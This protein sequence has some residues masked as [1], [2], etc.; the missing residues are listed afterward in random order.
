[1]TDLWTEASRD[2]DDEQN[3][4]LQATASVAA[5]QF[6]PFLAAAKT[7]R[8]F[9]HRLGYVQDEFLS[10]LAE[11]PEH[12]RLATL[13]K[14]REDFKALASTRKTASVSTLSQLHDQL[15]DEGYRVST[16]GSLLEVRLAE[17]LVLVKRHSGND[18]A[19]WVDPGDGGASS[20]DV[21]WYTGDTV[22]E[23]VAMQFQGTALDDLYSVS[24]RK[25]EGR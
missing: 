18:F 11:V 2:H 1:M 8:E 12:I 19:V 25:G 16:S 23:G 10:A 9:E 13:E 17:R 24:S 5:A 14:T 7:E 22:A 3:S 4:R 6:W 21:K 20:G 15:R